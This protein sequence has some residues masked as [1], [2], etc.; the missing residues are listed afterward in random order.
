MTAIVNKQ[1]DCDKTQTRVSYLC[2]MSMQLSSYCYL[3]VFVGVCNLTIIFPIQRFYSFIVTCYTLNRWQEC[4]LRLVSCLNKGVFQMNDFTPSFLS[5]NQLYFTPSL[6]SCDQHHFN[7]SSWSCDQLH[8]A[9]SL[10][11]CELLEC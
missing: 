1:R 8:L 2:F 6:W 3:P 7:L 5:G 4:Y 9:P 11:S 10:W